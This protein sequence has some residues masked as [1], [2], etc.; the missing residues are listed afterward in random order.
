[1]MLASARSANLAALLSDDGTLRAHVPRVVE[2]LS[3][4]SSEDPRA[5]Y[6]LHEFDVP[7]L[8]LGSKSEPLRLDDQCYHKL[9]SMTPTQEVTRS[10]LAFEEVLWRGVPYGRANSPKYRNSSVVF[11]SSP[12]THPGTEGPSILAGTIENILQSDYQ[13]TT[14]AVYLSIQAFTP[15]DSIMDPYRLHGFVAGFLCDREDRQH[16]LIPLSN[17]VSHCALTFMDA[18]PGM[19]LVHILPLDRVR[20]CYYHSQP[21]RVRLIDRIRISSGSHLGNN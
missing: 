2:S 14:G 17:L 1:M 18:T 10:V 12:S 11:R 16:H 20:A 6:R 7:K 3:K 9:R 21:T 5:F 4:I 15:I 19:K 8:K 13:N